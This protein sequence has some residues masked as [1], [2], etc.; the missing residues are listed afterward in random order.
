[1]RNIWLAGNGV[2]HLFLQH[3]HGI[4]RDILTRL[5][6]DRQLPD[7]LGWQKALADR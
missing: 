7:I 3:H 6:R 2:G 1:M 5:G 4:E